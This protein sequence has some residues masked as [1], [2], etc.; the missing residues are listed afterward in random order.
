MA[1]Q[2]PEEGSGPPE[3]APYPA[4]AAPPPSGMPFLAYLPF[5]GYYS[6]MPCLMVPAGPGFGMLPYPV[7]GAEAESWG[8]RMLAEVTGSTRHGRCLAI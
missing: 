6:A 4:A 1:S 2:A 3:A 8:F 7:H 5:G